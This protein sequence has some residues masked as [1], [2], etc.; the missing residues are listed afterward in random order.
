MVWRLAGAGRA[1][2]DGGSPRSLVVQG[3]GW[4]RVGLAGCVRFGARRERGGCTGLGRPP[5]W[6]AGCVWFGAWRERA[7][8]G[9]TAGLLARWLYR[10]GA[11]AGLGSRGV[12]VSAPAVSVVAVQGWGGRRVGPR[13]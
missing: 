7:G 12:Y 10:V 9:W 4:G 8:P 3:W 1:R 5:G 13:D 2:L 6:A 11:G